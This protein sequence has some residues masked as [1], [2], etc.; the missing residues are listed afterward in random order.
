[1]P[2]EFFKLSED[3]RFSVYET[4][5]GFEIVPSWAVRQQAKALLFERDGAIR[6]V[7]ALARY[8][9]LLRS[10]ATHVQALELM[11]LEGA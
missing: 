11:H 10:G 4:R 6:A 8:M 3:G 7:R 9:E 5:E 2:T 1:M